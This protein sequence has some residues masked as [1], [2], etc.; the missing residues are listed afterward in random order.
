[1][2]TIIIPLYT[3]IYHYVYHCIPL[4]TI[5]IPLH[6]IIYHYNT[7]KK[8]NFIIKYSPS[9]IVETWT[10]CPFSM[11]ASAA[12]AAAPRA[13]AKAFGWPLPSPHRSCQSPI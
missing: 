7:T 9:Y 2:Y 1:M 13:S 5:I 10:P 3:I 11:K 4:Y 12:A 8:K 6:T